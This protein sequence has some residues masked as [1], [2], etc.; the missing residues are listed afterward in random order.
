MLD[1]VTNMAGEVEVVGA[2]PMASPEPGIAVERVLRTRDVSD[3][4]PLEWREPAVVVVAEDMPGEGDNRTLGLTDDA[5]VRLGNCME[6]QRCCCWLTAVGLSGEPSRSLV[7]CIGRGERMM[8]CL[9]SLG[10]PCWAWFRDVSCAHHVE[11]G[12]GNPALRPSC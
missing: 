9:R 1:V 7:C 12:H 6:H 4:Q 3:I 11:C 2:E 10:I 8:G 5:A